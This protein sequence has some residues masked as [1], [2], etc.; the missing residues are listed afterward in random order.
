MG[1]QPCHTP[2]PRFGVAKHFQ[3]G[4]PEDEPYRVVLMAVRR[5]LFKTKQVMD[6]LYMG[7]ISPADA[8]ADATFRPPSIDCTFGGGAAC[9]ARR[10]PRGGMH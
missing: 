5:R 2:C 9:C 4:V 1:G 10:T 6:A 8:A 7:E 3:T